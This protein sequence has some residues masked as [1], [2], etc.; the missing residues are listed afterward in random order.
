M[1]KFSR[2]LIAV[3]LLSVGYVHSASAAD[4]NTAYIMSYFETNFADKDK[5]RALARKLSDT[6]NKEDG[7]LRFEFLQRIGQADQFSILAAWKDKTATA[8][9]AD[10][11]H[12]KEFR[13]TLTPMSGS[14]YDERFYRQIN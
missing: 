11:A 10:A 5:V 14:L 12:I 1:P 4:G 8:A 2:L 13:E 3:A 9:H 7:N 6:S